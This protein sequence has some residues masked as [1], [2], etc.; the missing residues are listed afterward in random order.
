MIGK[1]IAGLR[2]KK[3]LTQEEFARVLGVSRSAL[4]LWEQGRRKVDQDVLPV[5]A[6]Y[7]SCPTDYLLGLTD[8]PQGIQERKTTPSDAAEENIGEMAKDNALAFITA[9][10]G[11]IEL[12]D[13]LVVE[14]EGGITYMD[15]PLT[16]QDI[17]DV[18]HTI[19]MIMRQRLPAV[20]PIYPPRPPRDYSKIISIKDIDPDMVPLPEEF[21]NLRGE[22]INRY[23]IFQAEGHAKTDDEW[24]STVINHKYHLPPKK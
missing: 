7:F 8:N 15:V 20:I 24:R 14:N 5:I 6:N 10:A 21:I 9:A 13:I 12:T 19:A 16:Q 18:R 3:G 4:S 1:R 11:I 2:I 17:I 22:R 23:E